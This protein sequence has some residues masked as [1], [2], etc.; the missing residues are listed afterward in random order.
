M[1]CKENDFIVFI[2]SI[3]WY[4]VV[5][6]YY[7][8]CNSTKIIVSKVF[9]IILFTTSI[10]IQLPSLIIFYKTNNFILF[11]FIYWDWYWKYQLWFLYTKS[12]IW[13]IATS[14]KSLVVQFF[15]NIYF[16]RDFGI[17]VDLSRQFHQIFS[18]L[19]DHELF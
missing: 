1:R 4:H 18:S 15:V 13:K 16:K 2:V 14:C 6:S 12:N 11:K 19:D 8:L 3:Q 5:C 9:G 7:M 10:A 17:I